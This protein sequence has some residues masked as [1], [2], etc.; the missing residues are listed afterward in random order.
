MQPPVGYWDPAGLARD[1]DVEAVSTGAT[2]LSHLICG[3][4]WWAVTA[5]HWFASQQPHIGTWALR[6]QAARGSTELE[7]SMQSLK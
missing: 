3:L 5:M 4:W 6:P 7:L 1:G 2:E